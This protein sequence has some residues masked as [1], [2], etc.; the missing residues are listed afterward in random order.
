MPMPHGQ[1]RAT[2]HLTGQQARLLS[3]AAL[4]LSVVAGCAA[5]PPAPREL[6]ARE[7][8]DRA[9]EAAQNLTSVHFTLEMDGATLSLGPGL[10]VTSAEGD[11]VSPDRA[12]LFFKLRF[13]TLTADSQL[14]TI[15]DQLYL[16]NPLTGRWEKVPTRIASLQVLDAEHGVPSLLRQVVDPEKSTESLDSVKTYHIKGKVPTSAFTDLTGGQ[17]TDGL[18]DGE[19]WVGADDFLV[20]QVRLEGAIIAGDKATSVRVLKLSRFND[21]ISIEPPV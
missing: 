10:Q 15:G 19:V 17:P 7:V 2:E 13:G 1:S 4:L 14:V 20:R 16:T 18:V 21:P 12:H 8:L 6:T 11:V 3:V 9:A 5:A